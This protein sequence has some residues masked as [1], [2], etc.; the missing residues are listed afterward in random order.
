MTRIAIIV[1]VTL[2][3]I[4]GIGFGTLAWA[5]ASADGKL[6]E[7]VSVAGVDV[8]GLTR[9]DALARA[10]R[11]VKS[12]IT[13]PVK[14][15]LADHEYTLKPKAA[16]V[17]A[18]VDDA[19]AHAYSA[20][21][22]GSFIA[23]GWRT[24]TGAS[25]ATDEKVPVTIDRAAVRAF[26]ARIAGK[27]KRDPVDAELKLTLTSMSVTDSEPGRRLA[28]PGQL[29]ASVISRLTS[30]TGDRTIQARTVKTK[31]KVTEDEVFDEQPVAITV[32]RDQRRVR[33]FKRGSLVKTYTVAV[34]SPEYPSPTGHFA[35]QTKQVNPAWNVPNS[36]WAGSLAGRTIPGGDPGNPLVARWIGFAGSVGFHGTTSSSSLGNAASHGCVRMDPDDVIDLFDRVEIGTPVLVA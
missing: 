17:R 8:G 4:A 36:S 12:L 31:A 33:L 18:N 30:R 6:P 34:G 21:R 22:E 2:A 10:R 1:A 23:R 35:V 16:G 11:S 14:V 24:L 26:V 9:E 3:A 20:G 15:E 32:S 29:A 7:G 25:K 27:E 5:D 19:I 13:S 28:A